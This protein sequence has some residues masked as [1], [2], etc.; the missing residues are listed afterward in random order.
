MYLGHRV[1]GL[2]VATRLVDPRDRTRVAV[3][4][5]DVV[6]GESDTLGVDA[7]VEGCKHLAA[8]RVEL[9][10]RVRLHGD[11]ERGWR[12]SDGPLILP[13]EQERAHTQDRDGQQHDC[14]REDEAAAPPWPVGHLLRGRTGRVLRRSLGRGRELRGR[15]G[16]RRGTHRDSGKGSDLGGQ[17][18]LAGDRLLRLELCGRRRCAQALEPACRGLGGPGR[19]AAEHRSAPERERLAQGLRRRLGVAAS[20]R[21][22]PLLAERQE[23]KRV[24]LV[25]LDR[26]H[27]A[28]RPALDQAPV[29][30][31]PELSAKSRHLGVEPTHRRA[32]RVVRPERACERLP[33]NDLVRMQEQNAEQRPLACRQGLCRLA[34][35]ADFELTEDAEIERR[36]N[37]GRDGHAQIPTNV[38]SGYGS[39]RVT[40]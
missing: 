6:A 38:V 19:L 10:D 3:Q 27:I 20:E 30:N 7:H 21:L 12:R 1:D 16:W 37:R 36:L 22:P 23:A 40:A 15:L 29:A 13:E 28:L 8:R 9:D 33:R 4:H 24:E 26:E 25:L 39:L 5:P 31:L 2:D 14:E 11:R 35:H 32:E 18:A 34:V 17:I